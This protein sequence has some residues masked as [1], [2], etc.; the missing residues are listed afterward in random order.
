MK[1][2]GV[3]KF[4]GWLVG[5]MAWEVRVGGTVVATARNMS[6]CMR[7]AERL[8]RLEAWEAENAAA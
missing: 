3:G 6:D 1:K 4:E 5:K 8:Q 2:F 7:A